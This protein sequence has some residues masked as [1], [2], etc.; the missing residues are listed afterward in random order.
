MTPCPGGFDWHDVC[1]CAEFRAGEMPSYVYLGRGRN[2]SWWLPLAA[3]TG[4]RDK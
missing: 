3:S 2:R 1:R 4:E